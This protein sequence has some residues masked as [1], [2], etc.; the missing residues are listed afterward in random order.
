MGERL[1]D[2]ELRDRRRAVRELGASLREL[3]EAAVSTEVDTGTLR[4]VTARIR[5]LVPP[6]EAVTRDRGEPATVDDDQRPRRMY[7][8]AVGAG[9][10][11][12][13]PLRVE[14]VDGAAVG[15]CTL[16][17]MH[18]GPPSYVHGGVSAMLLDQILG[19]AHA[20]RGMPGMTVKLSLR[21]RRPVPL[22]TPLR[23]VGRVLDAADGRWTNS[24]ATIATEADPD[25]VLVEAEGSF[26][27]PTAEQ[28]KRL[29]GDRFI[30]STAREGGS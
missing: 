14:I 20:A 27:A 10:P 21:Y 15:T 5:E 8:P 7:N 18:E 23:L 28:A 16:G 9:N 4:E 25:T 26:V 29:F 11:F 3:T 1:S 13:P 24:V 12:A 2:E 17:L 30:P 19:H 6:L 22:K